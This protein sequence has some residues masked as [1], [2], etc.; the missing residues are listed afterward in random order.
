MT[1][2]DES[3]AQLWIV[4]DPI[5]SN[6]P[7]QIFRIRPPAKGHIQNDTPDLNHNCTKTLESAALGRLQNSLIRI[8]PKRG[9]I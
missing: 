9:R 8:R 7:W 4:R 3:N 5:A 6:K 2:F 1:V